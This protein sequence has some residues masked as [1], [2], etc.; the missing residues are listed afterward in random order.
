MVHPREQFD[1]D[2]P[3]RADMPFGLFKCPLG[4]RGDYLWVRETWRPGYDRESSNKA[5]I[6]Y[7][8][9]GLK[10]IGNDFDQNLFWTSRL[11]SGKTKGG[12]CK[13]SEK[14]HPSIHMP[15]WAS[16]ITLEITDVRVERVQDISEADAEAEGVEKWDCVHESQRM[17]NGPFDRYWDA[18]HYYAFEYLW[19][20]IYKN[21]D[22]NPWVWVVEFKR[23]DQPR[24]ERG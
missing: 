1:L 3:L 14:W 17:P 10:H 18:P 15:R 19:N 12:Q 16:R 20:Q 6:E 13:P 22:E 5:A 9:G 11:W 7:R 23:V 24:E 8:V 4:E 2:I 21:W